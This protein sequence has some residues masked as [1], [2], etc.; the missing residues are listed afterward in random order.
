MQ[1]LFR[2]I[3]QEWISVDEIDNKNMKAINYTKRANQTIP[4]F[5]QAFIKQVIFAQIRDIYLIKQPIA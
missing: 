1:T 3:S 2:K 4:F 5:N